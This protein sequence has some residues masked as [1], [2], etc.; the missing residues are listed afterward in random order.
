MRKNS[1]NSENFNQNVILR[2]L[3]LP[4]TPIYS[5]YCHRDIKKPEKK[6]TFKK[7]QSENFHFFSDRITQTDAS[8]IK[9][10]DG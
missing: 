9:T 3:V 2:C 6:I 8:I 4:T 1:E 5:V 10:A 7:L